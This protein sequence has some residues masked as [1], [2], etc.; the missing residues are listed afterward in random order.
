MVEE[1]LPQLGLAG[2]VLAAALVIVREI[3]KESRVG[4]VKTPGQLSGR[5]ERLETRHDRIE[6]S[7]QSQTDKLNTLHREQMKTRSIVE[8]QGGTL[9]AILELVKKD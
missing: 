2:T 5:V 6:D 9:D 1:L 4:Q 3:R 8:R 7:V